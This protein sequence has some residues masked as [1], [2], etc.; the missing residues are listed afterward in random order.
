MSIEVIELLEKIDRHIIHH[1][2]GYAVTQDLKTL[3]DYV[4]QALTLLKQQPKDE[5]AKFFEQTKEQPP[6][7]EFT[8]KFR[9]LLATQDRTAVV[10]DAYVLC[11][12][13]DR[14]EA[15]SIDCPNR[16]ASKT[17]IGMAK[18]ICDYQ[19]EVRELKQQPPAGEFTKKLRD[20]HGKNLTEPNEMVKYH[21]NLR[22]SWVKAMTELRIACEYIDRAE[23]SK[24][25][26]LTICV[27]TLTALK[28]IKKTRKIDPFYL[29]VLIAILEK[30]TGCR[31]PVE[32]ETDNPDPIPNHKFPAKAK[33]EG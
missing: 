2:C 19:D 6:A 13:L 18:R 4:Q 8:R 27:D 3:K 17:E 14:A 12:R 20:W 7:G 29:D 11:D 10:Q 30:Q 33:K 28:K 26:L 24:A 25:E 9:V 15:R 22:I 32:G 16:P 1:T 23:A 31:P 5:A 21:S